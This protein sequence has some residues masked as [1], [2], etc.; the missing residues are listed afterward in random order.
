MDLLAQHSKGLIG[1]SGC[2]RG[3]IPTVALAG[4]TD[5]ATELAG[6]YGSMFEPGC[7][8]LELQNHLH[9]EDVIIG[10]RL[11]EVSRSTGI[12]FVATND[13]HYHERSRKRLQDVLVCIKHRK[14]LRT[15]GRLLRPN[16]E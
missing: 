1:L 4:H 6:V 9:E 8:Y 16:S 15:A 11:I 7:F 13:V 12:P 10:N 5:H 3:E 2:K 14:T